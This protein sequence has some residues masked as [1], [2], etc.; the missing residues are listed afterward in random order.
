MIILNIPFDE[1]KKKPM[2]QKYEDWDISIYDMI[3]MRS[4]MKTKRKV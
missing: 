2:N 3:D 1:R 4:L